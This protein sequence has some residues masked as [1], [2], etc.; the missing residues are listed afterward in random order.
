VTDEP[1]PLRAT[2][3]SGEP[4][5]AASTSAPPRRLGDRTAVITGASRGLGAELAVRLA[6]IGWR[7]ILVARDFEQLAA[8]AKRCNN[9][10]TYCADISDA[11]AVLGLAEFLEKS[12]DNLDLVVNNA[13]M[14]GPIGLSSLSG[15][16]DDVAA[17]IGCNVSGVIYAILGLAPLI[18]HGGAIVNL[19]GAGVGGD[20]L[21][22]G[23]PTYTA[24]KF[25]VAGLTEAFAPLLQARGIS[26]N[27]ISPGAVDTGFNDPILRAG[28]GAGDIYAQTVQQRQSPASM[29]PFITL[30]R[31]LAE[32]ENHWM[33]GRLLSARWDTPA[34]LANQAREL[35]EPGSMR[36]RRIDGDL[37]TRV[38]Q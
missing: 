37:Y 24:S 32:P 16:A 22:T 33:T 17:T 15:S 1:H 28:A 4:A 29:E 8:T 34:S 6:S 3:V 2:V 26:I 14:L 5:A 18:R 30:V 10:R 12:V 11:A 20:G 25:A 31:F 36:L 35:E 38:R 7:L 23:T 21:A 19:A 9:A 27:A 13:G